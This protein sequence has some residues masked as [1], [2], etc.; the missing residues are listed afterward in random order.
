MAKN[1]RNEADFLA[2]ASELGVTV[3]DVRRA[4]HSYF[5]H[6]RSY[7]GRLP[8]DDDRKIFKREKFEELS[9]I[10]NI[11]YI[12]RIGPNYNRYLCW[13]RNES[14]SL[15]QV[16][17]SSYRV[18]ISQ[19]EFETMAADVLS[20]KT[21]VLPEKKKKSELYD[22]IWIVDKDGKK[23]AKQVIQKEDV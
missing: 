10:F 18:K 20:G 1:K 9:T 2:V 6:I 17:R 3:E 16:P 4:V 19:S 21:P 14:K 11:P 23:L 15:P 8:F 5:S 7:A 22:T 13:R 12:G